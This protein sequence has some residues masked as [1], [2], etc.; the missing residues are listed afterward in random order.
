MDPVTLVLARKYT[1]SKVF[2]WLSG[3]G[4]PS[5]EIG[6]EGDYYL[7]TVNGD[8]YEKGETQWSNVGNIKGPIGNQGIQGLQGEKGDAP[9]HQWSAT[10]L[11][12]MLPDG[13][14]GTFTDLKGQQGNQGPEGPRGIQGEPGIQGDE[15]ETGPP[16]P[17]GPPGPP[18]SKGDKGDPG[19][20]GMS[21]IPDEYGVLDEAK[22]AEIESDYGATIT[23]WYIFIVTTDERVDKT[24]PIDQELDGYIIGYDSDTGEWHAFSP[25]IGTPGEKGEKGDTGDPFVIHASG[26]LSELENYDAEAKAFVYYA[27]DTG[28]VYIKMS[29]AN[30]DWSPPYPFRGPKGDQG[31]QGPIGA[32]GPQGPTGQQ[33]IQG[34]QGEPG[35]QGDQGPKGDKGDTG[36]DA[37]L[38]YSQIELVDVVASQQNPHI[39]EI[40]T[41]FNAPFNLPPVEILKYYEGT[42]EGNEPLDPVDEDD[43]EEPTEFVEFV[44][45]PV[46]AIKLRNKYRKG[47]KDEGERGNGNLFSAPVRLGQL[48]KITELGVG[49]K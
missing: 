12:F 36:D 11:R 28:D 6:K 23:G 15:G 30:A 45:E 7:D 46:N 47:M 38:I 49:K 39:E 43:Y 16:G 17:Q 3:E 9:E 48:K 32:T 25:F 41:S 13:S 14:W 20:D 35:P 8:I 19:E 40:V 37:K 29:G 24:T 27:E 44:K 31:I 1:D 42:Y 2:V 18:G 34:I 10:S 5:D 26:P 33:G 22:I 21:F 4:S